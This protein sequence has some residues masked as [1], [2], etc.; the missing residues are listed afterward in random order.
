MLARKNLAFSLK[1]VFVSFLVLKAARLAHRNP[2]A[3]NVMNSTDLNTLNQDSVYKPLL[4]S[5]AQLIAVHVRL[6]FS[7]KLVMII[8]SGALRKKHA[9]FNQQH[10]QPPNSKPPTKDNVWNVNQ[11][12]KIA[13][14]AVF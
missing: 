12:S 5:S 11:E 9:N 3:P 14:I 13:L 1:M 7:A 2:T 4:R 10:A 6:T 8:I